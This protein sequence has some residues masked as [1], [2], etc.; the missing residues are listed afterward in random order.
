MK[1][2]EPPEFIDWNESSPPN[3]RF[4]NFIPAMFATG[5]LFNTINSHTCYPS[6]AQRLHDYYTCSPKYICRPTPYW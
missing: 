2:T 4:F 1:K 5:I 3:S 6:A